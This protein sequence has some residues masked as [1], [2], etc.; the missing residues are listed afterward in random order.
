MEA[1]AEVFIFGDQTVAFEPTLHSLLHIKDN[2]VLTDFFDRVGF[3]L[4]RH[5]G[6]L[7]SH[8]QEWFPFFT[9]LIDLFAQ[10]ENCVAAPALKF[11]LLCAT[12][13]GQFIRHFGQGARAY[14]APESTY[15]VGACTGAFAAAA[16]A[17]A[18]TLAEL[19][20]AAVEAVIVAFRTALRSMILRNDLDPSV[21]GR[22][23][24]W[25]AIVG[26]VEEEAR[27][28]ID[29]FNVAQSLPPV[30][31]LYIS[32]ISRTSVSV[33]GP[34]FLLNEFVSS[35]PWKCSFL[36]IELPYHAPHLFRKDDAEAILGDFH[37]PCLREY[38]QRTRV[39]SA[40]S[41][42]VIA[43]SDLRSLFCRAVQEALCDPLQ[44]DL[45]IASI[46]QEL[47]EYQYPECIIYQVSSRSGS[48]LSSALTRESPVKT[49]LVHSIGDGSVPPSL[50]TPTGKFSQSSIAIIGFSGRFPESGSNEEFWEML[51]A[52]RDVHRTIPEERFDWKAHY[53]P[54]GKTKNTSRVKYG[55][56]IKELGVFDARFFNMSPREAENADPAQRLAITTAYEAMEMAGLVPNATPSTQGD[57]IGVFYGVTSD[58]WREVNSG[59]N[60]DTYFIPGGNRAFIPGRISYFFRFCGPSL[61]ID[62]AC[63]SSCAAIQTACAYLWRGECDTALAGGVNVLTNPDNFCG[64]DRGHFLTAKGNCNAFDDEADGYCRSDAVG[65]VILKRLE[66][67]VEDNDPIFGVIRGAYT[68]HCGRT[69]SITRPF[70]GDQATVFNRIMRYAGVNP[71]DVGYVE[72]HGT[73]TQA[74]DATEMKSVLS[75]FAPD[76]RRHN[77]LFLGTAKAN[78]G[79]AES[80]SGVS[81]LIKVLLMMRNNTIPP[82][83]GIKTRINHTYPKDLAQR[84]VHIPFQPTPWHREEMPQSKRTVFLNNF[85]AAGGNT[86]MLIEDAPVRQ[87][88]PFQ[89]PRSQH[90]VTVT[91]K[92]IKALQ[93]NIEALVAYLE[94]Y[95]TVSLS[96]LAYTTTARRVHHGYRII[97]SGSD[98][99]SIRRRMQEILPGLESHRPVPPPAKLPNIV[100]VFTGQGTL[101]TGMGKQLFD[102]VPSF[103]ENV[104]RF[105]GMAV[106][107]GFPSF[108]PLIDG[109]MV[110]LDE[111]P[112]MMTHLALVCLQMALSSYWKS[113]GVVPAATIGH[114]LGEYPAL[115]A[116]GVLTAANV[117]YMVGTRAR[118]L[119]QKT[120]PRTHAMLAVKCTTDLIHP[121]LRGTAC[122]MA[123]FNQPANNV[124]SGPVDELLAL[125]DRLTAKG[126]ECVR[127]NIPYA[128]HSA[129]VDAILSDFR[130]VAGSVQY[131]VPTIPYISPLLGKVV[132]AG[133]ADLLNASY[134]TNACREPVNFQGALG[135]AQ[136]DGLVN[137]KTLWVEVGTHP[138]CSGMVK[139]NLGSQ[140]VSVAS[141]RKGS[142]PW[143]VV[144][145][146][147]EVLYTH[148]IDIQWTEYHRGVEGP[149]EVLRLPRYVWDLKNYWI[150][151]RN[152]FCLLKGEGLV[153]AGQ[154]GSASSPGTARIAQYLSPSVQRIIQQEDGPETSTLVAETD[155][156][157]RRLA[158]ILEGHV[159][160]GAMLSPSSLYADIALTIAKHMM[161]AI[162]KDSETAGLDVADM[163]VQNPLV[164]R[165]DADSQLFR[166]SA[167]ANWESHVISFRLY[168]VNRDGKKTS[169]HAAFVVRI[170]KSVDTWLAEWKRHA[171]L[172]QSRIAALHAS[173]EEGDAHKLKR[174]LAYQLFSAL[175]Q[176]GPNYQG[177]QEVVLDSDQHE[178]TARVSFQIDEDGFVFNPCW[179]DSLG[180]IAGFIMNASDATPSKEQVFINHGWERM[181]CAT[182][183]SKDKQ[184]QVYNRMQLETGTTY[185]GDTYIFEG[186][187]VVAVY[188]GIRFQG[189][190]RRLLDRLLPAKSPSGTPGREAVQPTKPHTAPQPIRSKENPKPLPSM[191]ADKPSKAPIP[192]SGGLAGRVLAII[193]KEAGIDPSDLG[194]NEEFANY[195][196][197]SLLSLTICGRIQEELGADVPSSIFVD[198]PTPKDLLGFFGDVESD[199]SQPSSSERSTEDDISSYET[200][201]TSEH[202]PETAVLEILRATIANETGVPLNEVTPTTAFADIGVDSLLALTIVGTL[203]E[204][205]E[206]NL[207]SNILMENQNLEEVSKALGLESSPKPAARSTPSRPAFDPHTGPQAT[208]IL[209]WGK[210]KTAKKILFLFPDGSGSATSYA[211]LPKLG[212]DTA[213]YGLNCPWMKT[214]EQMTV[215]LEELTA[216]Y[217][218]EVRRRQPNGPYYFGGWSAGGI[219]AYEAA[220]QL[221]QD[222]QTTAKLILID[223]PNPIGMENPPKRIYDF[224]QGIGLF[225]T[226]GKEPP[227]WLIPHFNAFIRL[228]D[229]YRIHPID[230][231]IQ[232]HI[233]YARDGICKDPNLPRPERRPD[234]PREMI[235]LLE[236]RTDFSGDGWASLLGRDNLQIEILSE[237]NHFSMMDPG[238][239]MDAF[240]EFLRRALL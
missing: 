75:V 81:S 73:G 146:S 79:H 160:N 186:D 214:P 235:W 5:V 38:T 209:L 193:A 69:D 34:P 114:S 59:Q 143:G 218:V 199:S 87:S 115:Y 25:S 224:F 101:Y 70:E 210:P 165:P 76:P 83:C 80:A 53:D 204:T 13:L 180:H 153:S 175:V 239:H 90:L 89:D 64:L 176:Y 32:S 129:Q 172:V 152:N 119:F 147:L 217:L 92:T 223:S 118:L 155:I 171:H 142:D 179:V 213:A 123:C 136:T 198:Y 202:D 240:G 28:A 33:S 71:L 96:S 43:S 182:R 232:T 125:K 148:G 126:I 205:L 184:Y 187:T 52:G 21:D 35:S 234:D 191:P 161:Q 183:F 238:K 163:Q 208:S 19:L 111:A 99:D 47:R 106:Q 85:S 41:A 45:I 29:K 95:P 37:D 144:S 135:T 154:Q 74:G 166:V 167:S 10:H 225:G 131:R 127:L 94:E 128:F 107:M 189:V 197:D 72:M 112:P 226:T 98:T 233:V 77:A 201:A 174:R 130:T 149:R 194:P 93:G 170:T 113:L 216:K 105:D 14:P 22:Q 66:D 57:R 145:A 140:S 44:W 54:T 2:A 31:R 49:N 48:L 110:N 151:Y 200:V 138:A 3:Q 20:P 78:M 120:T 56:F 162:G 17:S 121:E 236:N 103:R 192:S 58:D 15:L 18:Q 157:D 55:C 212:Q 158:P 116:A 169:D 26:T 23:R 61:S 207:P 62:T 211:A 51:L 156:H 16:I 11:P 150:P 27:S 203:A 159:V 139:G 109:S 42:E 91:A 227:S 222:G 137:D 82:H 164:S 50:A 40:T 7:P 46:S 231:S 195:G 97:V 63:S 12:Q 24:A 86:A 134:L 122:A 84:N 228:L 132:S 229:A 168:S 185:V 173:A 196:I 60:V 9:T 4:R 65:T 133:D 67:A 100:M 221:A 206:I 30:A 190:P 88:G 124:V 220:R 141:L 230:A 181:R 117:I 36:P 104:M 219:C 188:Q 1:P 215:S 178:A 39:I 8:Q 237:V 6:K 108:L 68:N 102:S 177:M